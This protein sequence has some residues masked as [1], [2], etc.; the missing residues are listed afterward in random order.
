MVVFFIIASLVAC[1]AP[2]AP[3][4]LQNTPIAQLSSLPISANSS[5]ATVERV[6][7][8]NPDLFTGKLVQDHLTSEALEGNYMGNLT[9]REF[10]V[11][12]PSGY[13]TSDKHYPVVY[14]LHGAT[15]GNDWL[16]PPV[17]KAMTSLHKQ[18]EVNEMIFVFPDGTNKFIG[19]LW[20]SSPAN[21]DFETYITKELVDK[22]DSTYRTI[23]NRNSRA[24]IGCSM[25]GMGSLHLA[26]KYPKIY[27]VAVPMNGL[28]MY[29]PFID[30]EWQA[31]LSKFSGDYNDWS[32]L[33]WSGIEWM[34]SLAMIASPNP[35][36]PPFYFDMPYKKENGKTVID[37]VVYDKVKDISVEKDIDSYLAQPIRLNNLYIFSSDED[38]DK[39]YEQVANDF[40]NYLTKNGVQHDFSLFPGLHCDYDFSPVIKYL[41]D[42]LVFE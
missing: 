4:S 35:N 28:Q 18:G 8:F 27:G 2:P 34:S 9:D 25:G 10:F 32:T 36:K 12:L 42:Y 37:Q 30:E 39:W 19:S 5:T 14:V 13:E 3:M 21:G 20:M 16:I 24:I 29:Q 7:T 40:D 38:G 23:P 15:V 11:Y 41:S 17:R 26:L 6:P 33:A 1:T 31:G 22:V